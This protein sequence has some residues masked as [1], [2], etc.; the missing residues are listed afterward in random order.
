ML[1]CYIDIEYLKNFEPEIESYLW[2]NVGLQNFDNFKTAAITNVYSDLNIDS[3]DTRYIMPELIL[4]PAGLETANKNY[5]AKI[6]TINRNRIVI[7]TTVFTGSDS[8]IYVVKGSSDNSTYNTIEEYEVTDTGLISYTFDNVYNYYKVNVIIPD[9]SINSIVSLVESQ[10]DNLFAYKW[11]QKIFE[12]LKQ[13][14]NFP[15]IA[16][17][18][19]ELY[20]ELF[21][22]MSFFEDKNNDGYPEV[23]Q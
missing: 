16:K 14:E 20:N 5:D 2:D 17:R 7:N 6:E 15:V 10:Y 1:K 19:S 3:S 23:N 9:G 12:N 21:Q 13:S 22:S 18:Y 11:L 8:K 4:V